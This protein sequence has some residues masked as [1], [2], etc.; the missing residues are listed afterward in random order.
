[1]K[2]QAIF[3]VIFTLLLC[4]CDLLEK[5]YSVRIVNDTF[6][7][8]SIY[9]D[10]KREIV[11]PGQELSLWTHKVEPMA[12]SIENVEEGSHALEIRCDGF[13]FGQSIF[14]D[15]DLRIMVSDVLDTAIKTKL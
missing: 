10:G 7:K 11:I 15:T 9:L 14:V 8:V 12:K 13:A 4:G 1:M 5:T 2:K 6:D 3:A